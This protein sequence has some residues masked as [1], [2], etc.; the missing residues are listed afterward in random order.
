MNLR[1]IVW[2]LWSSERCFSAIFG[3][4][5][6]CETL[7][8][9]AE[10]FTEMF[11]CPRLQSNLQNTFPIILRIYLDVK[12]D[13]NDGRVPICGYCG[14][15]YY[16]WR[17]LLLVADRWLVWTVR[18]VNLIVLRVYELVNC[19][20][21]VVTNVSKYLQVTFGI[22]RFVYGPSQG[23]SQDKRWSYRAKLNCFWTLYYF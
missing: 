16:L 15:D 19:K 13:E 9:Q 17:V 18:Q 11:V 20:N 6:L 1:A 12:L 14:P 2:T 5:E 7:P 8:N 23:H 4:L 10:T 21:V 3:S 22:S